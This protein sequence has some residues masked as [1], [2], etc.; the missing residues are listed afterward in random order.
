M[1]MII[2]AS[3]SGVEI[4]TIKTSGTDL[5]HGKLSVRENYCFT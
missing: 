2:T 3:E 4:I 5:S 1:E